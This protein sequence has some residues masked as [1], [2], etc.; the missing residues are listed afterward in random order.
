MI[1]NSKQLRI[2]CP[3]CTSKYNTHDLPGAP[4]WRKM[5]EH[6]PELTEELMLMHCNQDLIYAWKLRFDGHPD[7][8]H[9]TL[10][11]NVHNISSFLEYR[12]NMSYMVIKNSLDEK[13]GTLSI[14][15]E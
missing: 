14:L 10:V 9:I 5:S 12:C 15:I 7:I 13:L 1:T 2:I 6:T 11:I 3:Y 8:G 4:L